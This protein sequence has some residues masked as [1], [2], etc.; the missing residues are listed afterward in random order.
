[1]M[2]CIVCTRFWYSA[3]WRGRGRAG[4][5]GRGTKG[6]RS[7]PAAPPSLYSCRIWSTRLLCSLS[8]D[9]KYFFISCRIPLISVNN[10][11]VDPSGGRRSPPLD[12]DEDEDEDEDDEEVREVVEAE[13]DEESWS[14]SRCER[15]KSSIAAAK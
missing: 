13:E 1:M 4:W 10:N 5:E 6:R 2:F 12:E 14:S 15:T 7:S 9:W 8:L 11:R 3:D